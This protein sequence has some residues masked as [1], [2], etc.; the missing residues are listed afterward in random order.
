[1]LLGK[2]TNITSRE[3]NHTYGVFDKILI[4]GITEVS[5][6][7]S[8]KYCLNISYGQTFTINSTYDISFLYINYSF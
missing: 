4:F 1:M 6:A 2:V 3:S 7:N 8:S 5:V